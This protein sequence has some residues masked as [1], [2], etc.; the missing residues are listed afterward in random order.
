MRLIT[1]R[2]LSGKN[3]GLPSSMVPDLNQPQHEAGDKTEQRPECAVLTEETRE[4]QGRL[5]RPASDRG[6]S[7]NTGFFFN[8][9]SFSMS[10][11]TV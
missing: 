2:G 5:A 10:N 7:D 8:D 6:L 4:N 1:G 11:A 9:P 3:T